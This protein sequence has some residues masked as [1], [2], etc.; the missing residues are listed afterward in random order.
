MIFMKKT[1]EPLIMTISFKNYLL[2]ELVE[3]EAPLWSLHTEE[4]GEGGGISVFTS[5]LLLVSGLGYSI[6]KSL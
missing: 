4:A 6:F 2:N 1:K 3:R 5:L